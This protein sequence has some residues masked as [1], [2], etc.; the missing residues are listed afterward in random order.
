MSENENVVVEKDEAVIVEEPVTTPDSEL[1]NNN[2][3]SPN[4]NK[5]GVGAKI[6]EFFRKRAVGLKRK[7]QTIALLFLAVVSVYN[8]IT[9]TVFSEAIIM[10]AKDVQWVGLMVFINT[11]F[12]VLI[13]VTFLNT[14]PK[15]KKPN[16]KIVFTM[17]ESGVKLNINIPMLVLMILMAVAMIACE[18]VYFGL[19]TP[20]YNAEYVGN[21]NADAAAGLLIKNSLNLSIAHIILLA[22]FLV[23]L[24]TL[25]LY[26]K[27]IM[28]IN[29]SKAIESTEIKEAI[30]A[31]D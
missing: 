6:K 24:L 20:F 13:L 8:L 19:I 2:S 3:T 12:S 31:V 27:L 30:D 18:A 4:R 15:L 5:S 17:T 23:I 29:T 28:K 1:D 25:P 26:R 22:V 21:S 16:S 9:L 14:F 11:L 7:P 10:Y